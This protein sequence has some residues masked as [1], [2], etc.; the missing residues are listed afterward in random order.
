MTYQPDNPPSNNHHLFSQKT[1]HIG[2]TEV[3][4]YISSI[5]EDDSIERHENNQ[6]KCLWCNVK[7]QGINATKALDH[8]IITKCIH[9]KRCRYSINQAHLSRYKDLQCPHMAPPTAHLHTSCPEASTTTIC[10]V[11]DV[12]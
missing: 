7:F 12:S 8:V 11:L 1:S 10:M 6:S 3:L 4:G 2:N 9:I 5:W